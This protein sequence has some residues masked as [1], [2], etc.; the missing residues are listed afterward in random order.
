MSVS[1]EII[2]EN[3]AFRLVNARSVQMLVDALHAHRRGDK[4]HVVEDH[5][6]R[7]LSDLIKL[8]DRYH[9]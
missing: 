6:E 1:E 8:Q 5:V 2:A 9:A 4:P 3:A 7:V